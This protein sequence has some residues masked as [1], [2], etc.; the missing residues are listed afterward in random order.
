MAAIG[1]LVEG[2]SG[3]GK[4]Y[5][6]RKFSPDE[7]KIISFFKPILPFAGKY[8]VVHINPKQDKVADK[9]IRELKNTD[10]KNIVIDDFQFLLGVPMMHRIGERGWEKYND[11][12]QPYA[13]VLFAL[14]DLPDDVT[15]YFTSHTEQDENGRTKVKTIGKALDKYITIE[16]L[17]MIVL[18][19]VVIDGKYYFSTQNNGNNTVKSPEGM[20]PSL[21]I[22]ND[23]K[24]VHDKILAYY[25]MTGAKTAEE[26]A[27][28]DAA[29]TVAEDV[30]KRKR[31]AKDKP[32][33]DVKPEETKED[34]AP[35]EEPKTEETPADDPAPAEQ[36]QPKRRTTRRIKKVDEGVAPS[37][38]AA[39]VDMYFRND[40]T[41]ELLHVAPGQDVPNPAE[42]WVCISKTAYDEATAM[43]QPE[44]VPFEEVPEQTKEDFIKAGGVDPEPEKRTR[45]RRTRN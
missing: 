37:A 26:M 15:V 25:G 31:K 2:E 43:N 33:E 38:K 5:S 10:K 4:T 17:F 19:T 1:V 42:G 18:G 21:L 12:Q 23:L 27:A 30:G 36:E 3:T 34:P 35:V 40:N 44:E 6:I 7:V 45:R 11:I 8:E 41:D 14:A 13:D 24:Y 20:F 39:T 32:A 28:D 16:G 9:V 22:P 29:H